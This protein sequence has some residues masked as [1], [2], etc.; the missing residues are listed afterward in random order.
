MKYQKVKVI[1]EMDDSLLKK[2]SNFFSLN[3]FKYLKN[4]TYSYGR[5]AE[6]PRRKSI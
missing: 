2:T 3:T 6:Q 5:G 4:G 1:H